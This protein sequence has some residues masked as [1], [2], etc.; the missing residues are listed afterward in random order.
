MILTSHSND[1]LFEFCPRK[2]EFVHLYKKV[3]P[4]EDRERDSEALRVGSVMHEAAQAY[5]RT[6]HTNPDEAHNA[7]FYTLALHWDFEGE[8]KEKQKKRPLGAAAEL[9]VRMTQDKFWDEWELIEIEGFGV[10]IEVPFR[11]YHNHPLCPPEYA[12]ATQGKID[13]IMR[14]IKTGEI[15]CIDFKTTT[16]PESTWEALYKFSDQGGFYGFPIQAA[17]GTEV[18]STMNV[19]YYMLS[20][21]RG[22]LK[23]AAETALE[24]EQDYVE[25]DSF[26]VCQPNTFTYSKQDLLEFMTIKR[27]RLDRLVTYLRRG[28]FARSTA[29]CVSW[30]RPCAFLPVCHKRNRK[31]LESWFSFEQWEHKDRV[32]EPIWTFEDNM[33]VA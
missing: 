10:A 25:P 20:F 31:E 1:K 3:P 15:R 27:D 5:F 14:N 17:T 2:F 16:Q 29:G 18:G 26:L 33:E 7:M 24:T 21:D 9:L 12:L 13:L 32:Y 4:V 30:N 23:D 22:T 11:I 28:E 8:D 19:T 6:R